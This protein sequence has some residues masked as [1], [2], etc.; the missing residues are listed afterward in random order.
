MTTEFL[1]KIYKSE[2]L[3]GSLI[4]IGFHAQEKGG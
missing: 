1:S 3:I 4:K 2:M